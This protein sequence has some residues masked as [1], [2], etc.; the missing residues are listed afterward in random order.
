MAGLVAVATS[1]CWADDGG[2]VAV[3]VPWP[4][5]GWLAVP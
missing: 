2:N 3:A 4:C 5:G 1:D